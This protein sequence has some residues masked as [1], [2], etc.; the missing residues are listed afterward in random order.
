MLHEAGEKQECF[1]K[2]EGGKPH[3]PK[4]LRSEASRKR[5]LYILCLYSKKHAERQISCRIYENKH[6]CTSI[7]IEVASIVHQ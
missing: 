6:I 4:I 5:L 7:Y 2:P 1:R 3:F